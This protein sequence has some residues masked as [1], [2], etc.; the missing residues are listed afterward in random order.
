MNILFYLYQ[1]PAFGGIETVT[2]VL[3]SEFI[4]RGHKVYVLAH[5]AKPAPYI[6]ESRLDDISCYY[7]PDKEKLVSPE[8]KSFLLTIVER[9][10]I[11]RVIFQDSYARIENNLFVQ[12]LSE[13][14]VTCE[15]S[16]PYYYYERQNKQILTLREFVGRLK[17]PL[18]LIRIYKRERDRRRFL[19]N[20]SNYY[21][22]LSNRFF[23]EFRAVTQLKDT[24]KLLA[25]NNP[26][27][28]SYMFQPCEF[29]K[30][31]KII[32]FAGTLTF[33]K[34]CH[35]LIEA[36]SLIEPVM[37][38]WQLLI[39]GDG[40]E[41]IPL[42]QLIDKKKLERVS[43]LG[44]QG[45]LRLYFKRASI[46][47]FPSLREGW[48]LVL[49]EA[50]AYGCVPVCFDSFSS[51]HDIVENERDGLIIPAFDVK[52]FSEGLFSLS[53]DADKRERLAR[54]GLRSVTKFNIA[55]IISQWISLLE[56]DK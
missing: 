22:L 9:N 5:C 26:L 31:E 23:G 42:Q 52:A 10:K 48:G 18:E 4:R 14:I 50:L 8:N 44:Y 40:N 39:V 19:Y 12:E 56:V 17:Y 24:R 30:K 47:A 46:L 37:G 32:L 35:L 36:W 6:C 16:S 25:I 41:R 21:V 15:H 27:P 51:L 1:F 3:A 38:D 54:N 29:D 11:D 45:D 34:G 43:F 7:M 55:K 49:V 53:R 33:L 20:M 2:A 28:E 13:K